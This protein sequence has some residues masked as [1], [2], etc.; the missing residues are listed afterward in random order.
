MAIYKSV[1]EIVTPY[2]G[3]GAQR[4]V[5][6]QVRTHL[7]IPPEELEV[8]NLDEL[9]KWCLVSGKLILQDDKA[10]EEIRTKVLR[11]KK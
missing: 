2:L 4:F 1:V 6:R 3:L 11:L 9:A 7:G 8:K 10:A 5:E